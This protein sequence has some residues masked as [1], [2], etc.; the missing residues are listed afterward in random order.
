MHCLLYLK[1]NSNKKSKLEKYLTKN[2]IAIIF[3]QIT[4]RGKPSRSVKI[5]NNVW[6]IIYLSQYLP[7]DNKF[8]TV[9]LFFDDSIEFLLHIVDAQ[10]A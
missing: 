6:E 5:M 4:V 9:R 1:Q 3:D 2:L 8:K 10:N 7:R